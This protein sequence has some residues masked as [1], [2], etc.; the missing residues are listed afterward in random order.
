[1]QRIHEADHT[2]FR[3]AMNN[4]PENTI[5]A[6]RRR[7]ADNA[8][9][10]LLAHNFP[11]GLHSGRRAVEMNVN[12][13]AEIFHL[14][15]HESF[16]AKDAGVIH[17]NVDTA[18]LFHGHINHGDDFIRLRYIGAVGDRLTTARIDDL[19]DDGFSRRERISAI[20]RAPP[21]SLTTTLRPRG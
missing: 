9:I 8:A 17:Q 15:L 2:G 7:R 16:V 10:I 18:P 4:L 3:R 20:A 12:D 14:H 6:R 13:Q 19:L 11:D 5:E 21:R 1:M